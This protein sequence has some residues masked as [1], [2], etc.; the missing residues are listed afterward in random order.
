MQNILSDPNYT[1]LNVGFLS[2]PPIN[3]KRSIRVL[4]LRMARNEPAV[5]LDRGKMIPEI[6]TFFPVQNRPTM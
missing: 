3:S 4:G 5:N 1:R 2:S 6:L